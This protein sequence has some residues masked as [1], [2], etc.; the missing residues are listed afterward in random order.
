MRES[1]VRGLVREKRRSWRRRDVKVNRSGCR[2]RARGAAK[3]REGELHFTEARLAAFGN[4]Q[5]Q[6]CLR[7]RQNEIETFAVFSE[8]LRN[9][10]SF[11]LSLEISHRLNCQVH[12]NEWL[13]ATRIS[14]FEPLAST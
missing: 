1:G 2:A 7:S 8:R 3:S 11:L 14:K 10:S 12:C 5:I 6:T 9:I 4:V 13:Y